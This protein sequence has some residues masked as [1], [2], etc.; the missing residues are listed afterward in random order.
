MLDWPTDLAIKLDLFCKHGDVV[1][2]TVEW[3]SSRG[4][5][6]CQEQSVT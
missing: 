2:I 6:S 4:H 5:V 1:I 3:L